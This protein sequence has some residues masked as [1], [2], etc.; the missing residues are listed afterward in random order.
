MAFRIL[1]GRA[2]SL[3]NESFKNVD[4]C[5]DF[6]TSIQEETVF[7]ISSSALGQTTVIVI[8]GTQQI[9]EIDIF[10]GNKAHDEEWHNSE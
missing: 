1:L 10:S 2:D 5:I 8:H 6:T 7:M 3:H 4:E 9:S